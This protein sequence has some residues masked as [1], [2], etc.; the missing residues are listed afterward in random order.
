MTADFLNKTYAEINDKF[1]GDVVVNDEEIQY[2][3]SRIPHFYMGYYVYQYSTGF[4]A[5]TALADKILNEEEGA[6]DAYLGYLKSGSSDYPIEV[7]KKAGLDMTN[8]DYLQRAMDVFEQRLNQ[9]E[10]VVKEI[11]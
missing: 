4:C 8:K 2:E 10:E 5:A 11:K 6:L 7:M 3:W 1:Y 9:L